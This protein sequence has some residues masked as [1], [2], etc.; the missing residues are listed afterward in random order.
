MCYSDLPYYFVHRNGAHNTFYARIAM[1]SKR[2][3]TLVEMHDENIREIYGLCV[4]DITTLKNVG[5]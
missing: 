2:E 1:H 4:A 5:Q 3:A